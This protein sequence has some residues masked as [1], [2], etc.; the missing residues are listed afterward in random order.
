[1]FRVT[2][3]G[4]YRVGTRNKSL[5]LLK[6]VF[7]TIRHM[8]LSPHFSLS[9]HISRESQSKLGYMDI[10][11]TKSFGSSGETGFD[12]GRVPA[13]FLSLGFKNSGTKISHNS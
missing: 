4:K 7:L 5:G 9:K 3:V 12:R 6:S 13:Y 11:Y 1:M 10:P 2:Q 8:I